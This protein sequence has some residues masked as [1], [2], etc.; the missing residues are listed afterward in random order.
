MTT[1]R[2]G[3]R[4]H[5][6]AAKAT[7]LAGNVSAASG[8]LTVTIDTAA[9]VAPS[10]PDLAVASDSGA[11][12]TDNTTNETKPTF[13]GTAEANATVHAVRRRDLLGTG[14]ADASGLWSVTTSA[15]AAGGHAISAKA[16]DLA[17]N[18]S[19][20]SGALSVTIDTAAPVTPSVPDLAVASDSGASDT[21]N[22]TNVTKPTF[23]GTAEANATVTLFDGATSVGSGQA[24]AN[25]LWSVTT[26]ALAAGD[27]AISAKATD[28]AGNVSAASGALSVTIDTTAPVGPARLTSRRR[29]T[30]ARR[31]RQYDQRHHADLH[32]HC[33]R[34]RDGHAVR[35]WHVQQR[36]VIGSSQADAAGTWSIASSALAAG[37]HVIA[38]KATD[39]A[40]NVSV[41]SVPLSVTIDTTAPTAPDTPDLIAT[42]DSGASSTDNA[43]KITT[44][45]FTGTTEANATV[46]LLEGAAVVGSGKA[47]A[48]G[49]WSVTTSALADGVHAITARATD[50]ANNVSAASAAL[51][52]TIDTTPPAIPGIAQVT[53]AAISGNA[54]ANST[55]ALFDGLA[56]LG[57]ASTTGTGAWSM[58]IALT[59]GTHALTAKATD[60][61]GNVGAA[62]AAVAAVI[63]TLGNDVLSGGPGVA[64]ML[65]GTGNDT[66]I[67]DNALDV[68]TENAGGGIDKVV[69]SVSYTLAAGSEIE[70]LSGSGAVGLTLTGNEIANTII[71]TSGN[72]TLNGGG[73]N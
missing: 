25:G 22:T 71:G 38:A 32:R 72:D 53:A 10:V 67:V 48:A 51:S 69:A 65:G 42:S 18:V 36:T 3:D 60:I 61:A 27:H 73:G 45:T 68:V 64:M 52:I 2:F 6:I 31:I 56:Q 47:D 26:G 12:G 70:V 7:D 15:L 29:R 23:T 8:A 33:R 34:E 55:I 17:G 57:I 5:A 16:T 62:S 9:P 40:G 14:Q 66:Y 54:E 41:A 43:T 39:L 24:D 37:V 1:D 44:P 20:A 11:S 58:P 35:R 13:T 21:D 46:T 19:A 4:D 59:A 50:V 30:A 49:L 63:G 28:L